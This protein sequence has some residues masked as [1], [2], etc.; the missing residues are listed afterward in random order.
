MRHPPL[1]ALTSMLFAAAGCVAPQPAPADLDGLAR[2]A[3]ARWLPEGE[4]PAISDA[5]LADALGKIH[6]VLGGDTLAEPQKG[7]LGNLTQTELDAVALSDRDPA[8]PQ[9]IYLANV[10]HCTL[11]QIDALTLEPDQLS[12]YTEAYAAYAREMIEGTPES[13]PRWLTTYTS[14]EHALMANQFTATVQSGMR[15]VPDLGPEASPAGPGLVLRVYLPEPAVFE[16]E[17]AEFT[18]DYQVETLTERAP[19]ELV[20]FYG[21][22]RYMRYGV[23][24]DSYD[25]LM[26]DQTLQALVDWDLKT[27][28]LC[29]R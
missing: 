11:E 13:H 21:I 28:E 12:L 7:T 17:G 27:D 14:A 15:R 25:A 9:G 20:H 16:N 22:W 6:D 23:I 4:D 8:K 3:F 5:E 26:I 29:A 24:A 10:I 19:G 1:A 18:D 2:F